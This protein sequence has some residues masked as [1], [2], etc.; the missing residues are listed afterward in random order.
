MKRYVIA[1]LGMILLLFACTSDE[2]SNPLDDTLKA[3]LDR[4]SPTGSLDGYILPDNDAYSSIPQDPQNPLFKEKVELGKMLFFETGLALSPIHEEGKGTYSCASCHIPSAGFMPG[5]VQG[6]ADGGIGIGDHGENRGKSEHYKENE[7]DVQGARP[8]SLLNVAFVENTSW[9]GQFGS[10]GANEG[11]ELYWDNDPATE[12]NHYGFFGLES[13]NIEGLILHRM[14]VRKEVLDAYGYT[15]LFD[16]A[17]PDFPEEERYSEIT[18]SF[19]ISAYLRTLFTTE[20]PF[21]KW[22]KGDKYAMND[23]QKRGARLFFSKAGCYNCHNGPS[24]NNSEN[25]YAL[26]VKDLYQGEG[27]FNTDETDKRNFGRG[28]FTGQA[29]D[30]FKFKVPQLYN[31]HASPFYFHGSSKR[32]L[33]EVVEYFNTG[34]PENPNVPQE[35]IAAFFRPLNLT[36]EEIDD[37]VK[38]LAEGLYDRNVDRYAPEEVLS[39][40]CF[41]NNDLLSRIESGCE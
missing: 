12:V 11:T 24:L 22:L 40:N 28:G 17:F 3:T 13:Q 15:P 4:T 6:I 14:V 8:L 16:S 23:A 5:R 20:A 19:A 34:I 37:L 29:E 1:A 30:M 27:A 7:L 21:Q 26:G 9:S 36:D 32:S 33:K 10:N 39:G 41:P 31:M 25:F 18:A 38:F 35:N 2:L